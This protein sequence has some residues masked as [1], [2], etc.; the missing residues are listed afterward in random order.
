MPQSHMW[1]SWCWVNDELAS[2]FAEIESIPPLSDE[3]HT[4]LQLQC[5]IEVTER[6]LSVS[7]IGTTNVKDIAF[8]LHADMFESEFLDCAGME[9]FS[10]LDINIILMMYLSKWVADNL[11]HSRAFHVTAIQLGCDGWLWI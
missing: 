9:K 1:V 10:L 6:V 11:M 2:F 8:V 3:T 7:A 4:N 5:I